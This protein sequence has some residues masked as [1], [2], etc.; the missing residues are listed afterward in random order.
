MKHL[1]AFLIYLEK[2]RRLS[3]H[4]LIAYQGDL[5]SFG[6]FLEEM[7]PLCDIADIR[8]QH[9]RSW[10]V[11]LIQT[12]QSPRSVNR[13]I[14]SLR[15]YFKFLQRGGH[16]DINPST[17]IQAMKVP[18]RLP[19]FVRERDM[20]KLSD[21]PWTEDF[22]SARDRLIV[23][24]LYVT[25]MRRAE[26]ISLCDQDVDRGRGL[27]KVLG[28]GG[29]T[30]LVPITAALQTQIGGYQQLRDKEFDE[31]GH[32]HLFVTDGGR[33]LYPKMV[34]NCVKRY[35][36]LLTTMEKCS[37]H[38]LRHS[39]ATHLSDH[40]AD[41]NALKNLLGHANLAATQIYTHNSAEKL[42]L[43]Y[44]QAHPKSGH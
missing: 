1:P 3:T 23:D 21:L 6:N 40:G 41:I 17:T 22:K 10:M 38:V 43:V 33:V 29:K 27:L 12:G 35:L 19:V 2:E 32:K 15:S 20:A 31:L 30:R 42:K 7:Y 14:S 37:P 39:F 5:D 24:M 25:G 8:H 18:K 9:I 11:S 44:S 36:S 26:L 4:T 28:K 13:K 16:V 34:Y